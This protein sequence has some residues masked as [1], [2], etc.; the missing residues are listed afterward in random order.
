MFS[1]EIMPMFPDLSEKTI[2]QIL[3]GHPSVHCYKPQKN[4]NL[5]RVKAYAIDGLVERI[6]NYQIALASDNAR[7]HKIEYRKMYN[8]KPKPKPAQQQI[9]FDLEAFR[10]VCQE[11]REQSMRFWG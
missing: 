6:S 5:S 2:S 10:R 1:S 7:Q 8:A 11:H 3:R 4:G 9:L